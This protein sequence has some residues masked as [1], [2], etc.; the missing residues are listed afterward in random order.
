[1][2]TQIVNVRTVSVTPRSSS[3]LNPSGATRWATS[4][5]SKVNLPQAPDL[6]ALSGAKLVTQPSKFAGNE[7]RVLHRVDG[8]EYMAAVVVLTVSLIPR[9][10]AGA[11]EAINGFEAFILHLFYW[12]AQTLKYACTKS[13]NVETG[14]GCTHLSRVFLENRGPGPGDAIDRT[15]RYYPSTLNPYP[16][17][18]TPKPETRSR[19]KGSGSGFSL[20][21]IRNT[22]TRCSPRPGTRTRSETRNPRPAI[23]SPKPETQAPDPKPQTPDPKTPDPRPQTPDPRPQTSNSRPQTPDPKPQTP[24]PRLQTP[25]PKHQTPNIKP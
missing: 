12:P 22:R 17:T 9:Q 21:C 20:S 6:G 8:G 24:N 14:F 10:M 2:N 13:P 1:M 3:L 15:L 19:G 11:S 23:R 18:Q 5:S 4:L 16:E 25:D 7:P